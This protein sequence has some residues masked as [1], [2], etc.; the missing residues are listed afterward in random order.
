MSDTIYSRPGEPFFSELDN[1]T[2]GLVGTV[3]VRIIRKSD[4]VEVV[5]RTTE[6][7][8]E[9]PAGSG[10]YQATL[11]APD[12]NGDYTVLWDTGTVTP[13]TTASD[14]LYVTYNRPSPL[15]PVAVEDLRDTRVLIPRVR[16][17]LEGAIGTGSAAANASQFNDDQ[18]NALIADAISNCILYTGGLFGHQIIVTQREDAGYRAP[19]AWMVDPELT[20]EEASIIVAQAQLDY[21]FFAL[22]ELKVSE[23]IKDEATEWS[24]QLSANALTE[25]LKNLRKTR[26]EALDRLTEKAGPVEAWESFLAVRDVGTAAAIEPWTIPGGMGG[27]Q[28]DPRF[29]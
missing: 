24:Y 1:T 25:Y 12:E 3:G 26:D 13:E 11:T 23:T 21:F 27:Q 10:R 6:G 4:Q 18:V 14:D 22:K 19:V 17:G 9:S 20:E 8:V 7:I 2:S 28:L 16:R 5:A 29:G 15:S